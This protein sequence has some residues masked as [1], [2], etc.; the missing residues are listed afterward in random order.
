[1]AGLSWKKLGHGTYTGEMSRGHVRLISVRSGVAEWLDLGRCATRRHCDPPSPELRAE[2][3]GSCSSMYSMLTIHV[4]SRCCSILSC[5]K[6]SQD[7]GSYQSMG[8][9][10]EW[11]PKSG[12]DRIAH[13]PIFGAGCWVRPSTWRTK[14]AAPWGLCQEKHLT[15]WH[16]F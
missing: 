6:M 2:D 4:N 10:C 15:T 14:L 12:E 7:I 11:C 3:W 16:K 8:I 1:M 5:L 9:G 13:Q